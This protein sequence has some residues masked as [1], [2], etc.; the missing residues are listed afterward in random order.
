MCGVRRG[1]WRKE[2]LHS[3][4]CNVC[5][6]PLDSSCLHSL[7][8]KSHGD[9]RCRQVRGRCTHKMQKTVKLF[10]SL[11]NLT[12]TSLRNSRNFQICF[13]VSMFQR[14]YVLL[15][16][17]LRITALTLPSK[18]FKIKNVSTQRLWR[19][20][21]CIRIRIWIRCWCCCWYQKAS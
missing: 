17:S 5:A 3:K 8:T 7:E 13:N 19:I 21:I 20:W 9:G 18:Q 6:P 11:L 16:A 2:E 14:F 10:S 1:M 4:F 15:F 12:L